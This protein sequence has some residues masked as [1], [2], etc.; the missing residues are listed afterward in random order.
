[1][2]KFQTFVALL[3]A[4]GL[5]TANKASFE[6]YRVYSVDV[7][8]DW[9]LQELHHLENADFGGLEFWKSPSAVGQRAD[10]MVAPHQVAMFS[11][12]IEKL[13]LSSRLMVDN[14]QR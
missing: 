12:T 2:Y 1:M 4:A 11:E 13:R 10:I 14:V 9:Q 3:F 6:N 7:E 5:V 8:N